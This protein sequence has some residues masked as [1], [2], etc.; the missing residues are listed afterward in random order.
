ME[1]AASLSPTTHRETRDRALASILSAYT[2]AA[3][4]WLLFATAV[5]RPHMMAAS[6]WVCRARRTKT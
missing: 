3:T 5:E 6:L 4:L 2:A 1:G